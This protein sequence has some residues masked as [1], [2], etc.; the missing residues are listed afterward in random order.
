MKMETQ[1]FGQC[2]EWAAGTL[3]GYL[4]WKIIASF[5]L[6]IPNDF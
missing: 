2:N 4:C 3:D 1:C 5:A 6:M